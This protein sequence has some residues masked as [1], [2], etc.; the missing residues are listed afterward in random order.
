MF[1][2]RFVPLPTGL[3]ERLCMGCGLMGLSVAVVGLIGLFD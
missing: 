1:Q 3:V 2:A